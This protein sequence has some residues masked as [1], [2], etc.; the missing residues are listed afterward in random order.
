MV[1]VWVW[2]N[3]EEKRGI[4]SIPISSKNEQVTY[5]KFVKSSKWLKAKAR[6]RR[7]LH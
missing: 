2:G 4:K 1:S 5:V 7:A 6:S 3:G